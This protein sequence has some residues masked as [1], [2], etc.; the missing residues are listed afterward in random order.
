[1]SSLSHEGPIIP[2]RYIADAREAM[3]QLSPEDRDVLAHVVA[4]VIVLLW[5][6]NDPHTIFERLEKLHP[7]A[8]QA[9]ADLRSLP[10]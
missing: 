6:E 7:E 8:K 1:M 5:E 4:D 10:R 3:A 9:L 2:A